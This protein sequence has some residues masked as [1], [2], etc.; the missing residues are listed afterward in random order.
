MQYNIKAFHAK[1]VSKWYDILTTLGVD[2]KFLTGKHTPC[3]VCGGKDRFRFDDKDGLGT[4]YCNQCQPQAGDGIKLIQKVFGLNFRDALERIDKVIDDGAKERKVRAN[5]V[6]PKMALN[7]LWQDSVPLTGADPASKY[8]ASRKILTMSNSKN[9]RYCE[10]CYHSELR[11]GIPALVAKIVNV[12]GKPVS[13][14]RIYLPVD[15][16]KRT[17]IQDT[18]KIMPATEL[19]QGSSIRLFFPST[20]NLN[21]TT[22]G[23]AEGIETAIATT[24]LFNIAT[25]ACLSSTLMKSWAIPK[26]YAFATEKTRT[27]IVIFADND[28]NFCGQ[29]AAYILAKKLYN[30]EYPVAVKKPPKSGQDWLDYLDEYPG[31]KLS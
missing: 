28:K 23:I 31:K 11:T 26:E 1:A 9:V 2:E 10:K 17:D 22:L 3:P 8:L 21:K 6:D 24:M 29:E 15:G 12:K 30:K 27:N 16:K 14:Q 4:W 5:T 20:G 13:I 7:K 19:L 25:W 18:K